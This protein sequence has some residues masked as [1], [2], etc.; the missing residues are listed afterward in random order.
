M[1]GQALPKRLAVSCA[2][3][4]WRKWSMA[5]SAGMAPGYRA[6]ARLGGN[7]RRP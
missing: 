5:H 2:K 3:P 6:R 4:S 1:T 7:S